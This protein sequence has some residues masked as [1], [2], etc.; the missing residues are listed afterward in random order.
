MSVSQIKK[1][2]EELVAYL[3]RDTRGLEKL[4]KLKEAVN[5]LRTGLASSETEA[6]TAKDRMEMAFTESTKAKSEL[7]AAQ[8]ELHSLRQRVENLTRD[9]AA[10]TK[11][12]P[13]NEENDE[14]PVRDLTQGQRQYRAVIKELRRQLPRCPNPTMEIRRKLLREMRFERDELSKGW[15]HQGI[16]A[17]GASVAILAALYGEVIIVSRENV[18][19]LEPEYED[20]IKQKHQ[21]IQWIR[22]FTKQSDTDPLCRLAREEAMRMGQNAMASQGRYY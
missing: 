9:L 18:W 21:T 4:R 7:V 19:D 22:H 10:E 12:I 20:G 13:T 15:S 6:A 2:F 16:W 11:T 3:G 14:D 5:E 1:Q 17:L 8:Q